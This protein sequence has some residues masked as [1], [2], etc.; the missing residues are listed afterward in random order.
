ML[1]QVNKS[2]L[3]LTELG[4]FCYLMSEI[5]VFLQQKTPAVPLNIL[6]LEY[7]YKTQLGANLSN[8]EVRRREGNF[9]FSSLGSI[10][11]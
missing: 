6:Q 7:H 9:F 11:F 1:L 3:V 8:Q 10:L 2:L 4:I 5:P